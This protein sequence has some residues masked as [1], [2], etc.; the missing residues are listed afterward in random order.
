MLICKTCDRLKFRSAVDLAAGISWRVDHDGAGL[1]GDSARQFLWIKRP[2]RCV[3]PNVD[4]Y[5]THGLQCVQMV[6]IVR[7]EK[8]DLITG[9]QQ[10]QASTIKSTC[11]TRAYHDFIVWISGDF[12]ESAQAVGNGFA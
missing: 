6:A 5:C 3:H 4:G 12:V 8:N 2:I 11:R 1:A 9:I 10:S 7:L